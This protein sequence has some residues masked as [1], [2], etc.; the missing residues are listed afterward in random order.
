MVD[1]IAIYTLTAQ[2]MELA[3]KLAEGMDGEATIFA[4][5]RHAEGQNAMA[6]DSLAECVDANFAR[7]D[8][9]VFIAA[10]G[11][12]IRMIASHI[13]NKAADPAVVCLDQQGQ[14]AVSLLSGHLGGGNALAEQCAEIL[15]GQAVITTATDSA[16]VPS[17][18]MLAAENG[19]AIGNIGQVKVV[20]GALL[21]KRVV[22]VYDSDNHLGLA[23]DDRFAQV[24]SKDDWTVG[25]PG[26]WVSYRD[27]CPDAEALWLY[28][29]I[30]MLGVGCRRGVPGDEI[31]NHIRNVFDA[32]GFSLE[33]IGGLA[34]VDLKADEAGLLETAANL[35]VDP[36]FYDRQRLDAVE[37]PN[38]SGAVMRRVGVASVSEASALLLSEE[39][40]LLV[41]KTKTKTVTLAVARKRKRK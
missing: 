9:H 41:E 26:A 12:V 17:V 21:D 13:Q 5:R 20:N 40:E 30:L 25:V 6:F 27:D 7:F 36:V 33:A 32:A 28:P 19:L 35:G 10:A 18:D 23:G 16:G 8:G 39:G 34:S 29:R 1:A 11:I 37:A 38:P 22:Q 14:F 15:G 4:T 24:Q 31:F 3:R 2:G